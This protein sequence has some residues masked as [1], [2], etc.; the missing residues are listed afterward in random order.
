MR[1]GGEMC[2]GAQRMILNNS[3]SVGGI[4][5]ASQSF[6]AK[7]STG[8]DS[9]SAFVDYNI[10][11]LIAPGAY[12]GASFATQLQSALSLDKA[13]TGN[14]V[15][16]TDQTDDGTVRVQSTKPLVIFNQKN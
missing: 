7:W 15:T 11:N 10:C 13:T 3:M 8:I 2:G 16:C 5:A 6:Q 9:P 12:T 14:D 4:P 1:A